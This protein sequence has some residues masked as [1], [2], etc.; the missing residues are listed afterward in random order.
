MPYTAR[1][2]DFSTLSAEEIFSMATVLVCSLN[3]SSASCNGEEN[4]RRTIASDSTKSMTQR[5]RIPHQ[6]A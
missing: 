2:R 1:V 3:K 6:K 4:V 5:D